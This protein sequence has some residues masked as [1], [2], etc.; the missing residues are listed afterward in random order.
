VTKT[1]S[2]HHQEF[3]AS[4]G[5]A[6]GQWTHVEDALCAVYLIAI[7][8]YDRNAPRHHTAPAS[9]AFHAVVSSDAKAQMAN[10]AISLHF[11][12]KGGDECEKP[13]VPDFLFLC[14]LLNRQGWEPGIAFEAL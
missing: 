1:P 10:A 11:L 4:I 2:D 9:A 14:H 8:L 3:Y 12:F 7:G 13:L 5:M 6:I